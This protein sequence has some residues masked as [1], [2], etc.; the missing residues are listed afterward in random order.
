MTGVGRGGGRRKKE[1]KPL[2]CRPPSAWDR[3]GGYVKLLMA[4]NT[5]QVLG[6]EGAR[7]HSTVVTGWMP[8][9]NGGGGTGQAYR[10]A[11]AYGVPVVDLA[12]G[13]R[14]DAHTPAWVREVVEQAR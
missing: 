7:E 14:L 2:T 13:A 10:V 11:R 12:R 9:G 5:R 1:E 8:G 6:D 4:R 3:L